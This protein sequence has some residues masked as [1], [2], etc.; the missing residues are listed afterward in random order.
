M[1][2]KLTP[3]DLTYA[4]ADCRSCFVVGVKRG[5]ERL[6]IRVPHGSQSLDTI[7]EEADYLHHHFAV[8]LVVLDDVVH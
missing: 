3:A 6:S 2:Y 7:A 5:V 1:D 8:H 4:Y